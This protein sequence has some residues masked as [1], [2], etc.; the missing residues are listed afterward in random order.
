MSNFEKIPLLININENSL[1]D[2]PG[3]RTVFF[4]KGCPLDC[5]WCQNPESK[6]S[7]PELFFN[8]DNCIHCDPCGVNC[9]Q[10]AFHYLQKVPKIDWEKCTKC[11]LCVESCPVPVFVVI[12]KSYSV[13]ELVEIAVQ[14]QIFY[15][16]T[17][18]G[19]TLSGGDPL[20]FPD[21]VLKLVNGLA[22]QNIS[23]L[24][25]TSGY[26]H[27]SDQIQ[28]ILKNIDIIYFDLKIFDSSLHQEYCGVPNT[29]IK[30]NFSDL[31]KESWISLIENKESLQDNISDVTKLVPRIPLIPDLT[32]NEE[33]LL[34]WKDFLIEN[35]VKTID[36]LPYNPLWRKKLSSMGKE[37]QFLA[38]QWLNKKELTEIH[39]IFRDFHFLTFSP[40]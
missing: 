7:F 21:Y 20:L 40:H 29:R 35:N 5:V 38:N 17:N 15:S 2:G 27:N 30:K 22:K 12:G 16:N 8:S 9:P 26:F 18:G 4:F 34:N 19:I 36:L 24:V 28:E 11:F 37:T 10:Y 13:P 23:I 33:N 25:E 39:E 32:I 3:I 6:N 14:N 1:D 31:C